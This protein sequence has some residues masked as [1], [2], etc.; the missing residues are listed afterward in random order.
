MPELPEVET[1][2]NELAPYVI[3]HR[4]T[5]IS[6]NWE[7][8]VKEPKPREF[9]ARLMGQRITGLS[10]RGKY[11]LFSLDSGEF[12]I[13]HLKMTGSLWLKEPEKFV[14]AIIHLDDGTNIYFRDPRKFGVMW[15]ADDKESVG[16]RLGPEALGKDFT[17][18]VLAERPS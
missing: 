6:I 4:I 3:G 9:R 18:K 17:A 7:G 11:L 8:M 14:R 12:L 15:L 1:V 2:K 10:R 13:V 5:G 16:G